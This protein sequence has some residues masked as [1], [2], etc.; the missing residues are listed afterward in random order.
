MH[1][2]HRKKSAPAPTAGEKPLQSLY[3][4]Y[5][6]TTTPSTVYAVSSTPG[7][8]ARININS[9]GSDEYNLEGG[10]AHGCARSGVNNAAISY[11]YKIK[12]QGISAVHGH[13]T[14][15]ELNFSC[16]LS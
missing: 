7:R 16:Q 2:E 4:V 5:F 10:N 3:K 9:H 11:K 12:E 15:D 14:T 1:P 6:S 8:Q 13:Y